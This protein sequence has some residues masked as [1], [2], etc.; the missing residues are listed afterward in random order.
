MKPIKNFV[1]NYIDP[2]HNMKKHLL[3]NW[4]D[5]VGNLSKKMHVEKIINNTIVVGVHNSAWIHE[6]YIL[7]QPIIATINQHFKKAYI[8]KIIFKNVP[9]QKKT[10]IN[11]DK[12]IKKT[13]INLFHLT[14][15]EKK[16]LEKIE[17]YELKENLKNFLRR[18]HEEK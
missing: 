10:K 6:L 8:K 9:L 15:N 1:K 7:S 4:S 11:E 13:I 12:E 5:I 3:E 2:S 14:H 16:A 17:D 18:C